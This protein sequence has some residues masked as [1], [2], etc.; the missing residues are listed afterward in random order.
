MDGIFCGSLGTQHRLSARKKRSTVYDALKRELLTLPQNEIITKEYCTRFAG[1]LNIDGVCVKVKGYSKA[2]PFIFCIDFETHDIPAGILAEAENDEA[3]TKLFQILKDIGYPLKL[4]VADENGALKPALSR[5]FP[6]I[7]LQLCQVHVLRNI[8]AT[9]HLSRQNTTHLAFFQR[10]QILFKMQG[11]DSRRRYFE[12][13]CCV[14][15]KSPLYYEIIRSLEERWH[16][17]F[18][19]ESYR[20]QGLRV[21]A[22]NNLIEGYNAQFKAR[23]DSIKGFESFSSAERFV[24]AWMIRR[25]FTPFRECGKPFEHLNGHSSFEKSRNPL[26]PWPEIFGI[27]PRRDT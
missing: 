21:P 2:I 25:R 20:K 13:I 1:V 15:D 10:I 4:V 18:R 19:F 6:G 26:L 14:Y 16:D 9:L 27:L 24:N 17:L 5:V 22:T 8:K 3:F 12:N 7:E 11:E 23:A